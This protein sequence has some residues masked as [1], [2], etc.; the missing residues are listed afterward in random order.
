[1]EPTLFVGA[2]VMLRRNLLRKDSNHYSGALYKVGVAFRRPSR[3]NAV[4]YSCT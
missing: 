2:T 1:M 4:I 3:F